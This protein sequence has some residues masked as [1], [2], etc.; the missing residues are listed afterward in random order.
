[1]IAIGDTPIVWPG[2]DTEYQ[3]Q[4]AGSFDL[5]F[6]GNT[7]AYTYGADLE[8]NG[9]APGPLPPWAVA[10]RPWMRRRHGG[11]WNMIFCD[12]HLESLHYYELWNYKSEAVLKRWS[13]D[14]RS[15]IDAFRDNG[16]P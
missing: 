15:H 5:S 1:M 3:C 16:Y 13:R 4:F 11:R 14:N 2:S 9:Y 10:V 7:L 8:G 6:G 12:G